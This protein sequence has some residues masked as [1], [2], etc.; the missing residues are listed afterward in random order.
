MMDDTRQLDESSQ[1]MNASFVLNI[2]REQK[3]KKRKASVIASQKYRSNRL[4]CQLL[5]E[6]PSIV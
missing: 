6:L 1:G 3:K 5:P 2:Q 4:V